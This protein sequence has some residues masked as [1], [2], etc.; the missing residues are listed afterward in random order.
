M[1]HYEN[2]FRIAFGFEIEV[3]S[4][5]NMSNF[6]PLNNDYFELAAYA[7]K[8]GTII[9]EMHKIALAKC[10][11]NYLWF[12]KDKTRYENPICFKD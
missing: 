2:S 6:D 1:K 8:N 12:I 11:P 10:D 5:H 4:K 7:Q 9:R 3:M